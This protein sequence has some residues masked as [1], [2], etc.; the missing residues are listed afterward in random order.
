MLIFISSILGILSFVFEN[1]KLL[2]IFGVFV[3]IFDQIIPVVTKKQNSFNTVIF[4]IIC[5]SL[6]GFIFKISI[7]RMILL[8]IC[9]E[10]FDIVSILFMLI[11]NLWEKR[12]EKKH[13][14]EIEESIERLMKK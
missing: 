14:Q 12:Y 11:F 8:A 7:F 3:L 4:T 9:I 5:T 10:G 2:T 1:D 13:K 6:I